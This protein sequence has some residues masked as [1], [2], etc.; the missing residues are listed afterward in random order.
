[1]RPKRSFIRTKQAKSCWAIKPF[2][3]MLHWIWRLGACGLWRKIRWSPFYT[4]IS[5]FL[6]IS[7]GAKINVHFSWARGLDKTLKLNRLLI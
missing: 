4:F 6:R 7:S 2:W 1:M 3:P 5:S